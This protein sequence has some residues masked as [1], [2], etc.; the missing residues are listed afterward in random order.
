MEAYVGGYVYLKEAG[1]KFP[2]ELN[3]FKLEEIQFEETKV[4]NEEK[5]TGSENKEAIIEKINHYEKIR[6]E[7]MSTLQ[8]KKHKNMPE[9]NITFYIF[10]LF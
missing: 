5:E 2:D 3:Y 1:V 4:Q 8:E 6:N 9:G 10:S 7:F